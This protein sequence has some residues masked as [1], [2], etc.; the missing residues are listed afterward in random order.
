MYTWKKFIEET[1]K[2]DLEGFKF[3]DTL[4]PKVWDRK[5]LKSDVHDKLMVI[6]TDFFVGLGFDEKLIDDITFTGSLANYNWSS[7]NLESKT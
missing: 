5:H 1:K 7:Y 3:Q 4:N 2:V 6:A